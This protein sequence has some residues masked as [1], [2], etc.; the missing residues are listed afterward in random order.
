[1]DDPRFCIVSLGGFFEDV[2]R[3]LGR[4]EALDAAARAF[5]ETMAVVRTGKVTVPMLTDYGVALKALRRVFVS[6]PEKVMTVETLVAIYLV[7]ICQV[8]CSCILTYI[9]VSVLNFTCW[10]KFLGNMANAGCIRTGWVGAARNSQFISTD[11]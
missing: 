1:M 5:S 8:G 10:E 2:P 6:A 9:I 4:N 11:W 7:M 3:R